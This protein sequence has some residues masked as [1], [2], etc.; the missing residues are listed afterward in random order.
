M[1]Q[2]KTDTTNYNNWNFRISPYFW[3]VGFKGTIYRP[4]QPTLLPDPEP[5][6]EIDV[7]YGDI[8]NHLKFALMIAG[9]YR[10]KNLTFQF[11]SSSIVLQSEFFTPLE[12]LLQGIVVNFTFSSGD[13]SVGYRIIKSDKIDLD[14][15]IGLK[16]VFFKLKAGANLLGI[17]DLQGERSWFLIDPVFGYK[18]RYR[19]T[20]KIEIM[21]YGDIGFILG[22]EL[23]YQLFAGATYK[24]TKVFHTSIIYRYWALDVPSEEAIY[25]GSIKGWMLRIGF[26]F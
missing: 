5:S 24:F 21:S 25:V 6:K 11:N 12:I 9:E 19:P 13:A 2:V 10:G 8:H 16:F 1:S 7:S 15:I 20:R 26:Q 4:P 23:S 17:K 3:F 22:N 14:A 18:F